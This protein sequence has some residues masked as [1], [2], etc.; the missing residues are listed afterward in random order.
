MRRLNV[1]AAILLLALVAG[2]GGGGAPTPT[3]SISGRVLD[4]TTN[5]PVAGAIVRVGSRVTQ[6]DSAGRYTL[7]GIA[8]GT[9]RLWITADEH[10]PYF[11]TM[12]LSGTI[13][14]PDVRLSETPEVNFYSVQTSGA[15]GAITLNALVP[16]DRV[17]VVVATRDTG[18]TGY[19]S[20]SATSSVGLSALPGLMVREQTARRQLGLPRTP[21]AVKS[22]DVLRWEL[23]QGLGSRHP[24]GAA[25]PRSLQPDFGVPHLVNDVVNFWLRTPMDL[26]NAISESQWGRYPAT[27]KYVSPWT[28]IFVDNRQL[29][30]L[31][32][33]DLNDLGTAFDAMVAKT[34]AQLGSE[35]SPGVDQDAH[36]Y[37]LV[38]DLAANLVGL[39][40]PLNEY[41]DAY[42][43]SYGQSLNPKVYFHSNERQM[44]YVDSGST[45]SSLKA[46]L[47]HEFGHMVFFNE[48]NRANDTEQPLWLNEAVAE[49]N[50]EIN[51]YGVEAGNS[52]LVGHVFD[53]LLNTPANSLIQ[54]SESSEL[55][56]ADYGAAYLFLRYIYDRFGDDTLRAILTSPLEGSASVAD[57]V[58]GQSTFDDLFTDWTLALALDHWG[59]VDGNPR[60][61]Y[62]TNFLD[63]DYTVDFGS[64][65]QTI[66]LYGPWYWT[67]IPPKNVDGERINF[68]TKQYSAAFAHV[69][70]LSGTA[71]W[72]FTPS[73]PG[74]TD[75]VVI[76][77]R[78]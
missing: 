15:S 64:G 59:W 78:Y 29:G 38:T 63:K 73:A 37:I 39:F 67:S 28:Y 16:E 43:Y 35:D 2:C 23:E 9:N 33:A 36:I 8:A 24:R 53:F 57:A 26:N 10:E 31:A 61:N 25:W 68:Q 41:T 47:A 1:L 48:R 7:T 19:S 71:T 13:P 18:S 45:V 55:G 42:V 58:G 5:L 11:Q 4:R 65:P 12:S 27:C 30:A 54:W 49:M 72:T 17:K 66:G 60:F 77:H 14:L 69:Q 32:Q 46:A 22:N 44:F 50:A 52:L 56:V 62:A 70:G 3:A 76:R 51:G 21:V 34:H 20:T 6:T 74:A 75:V 40:S